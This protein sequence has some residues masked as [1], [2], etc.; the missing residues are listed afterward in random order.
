MRLGGRQALDSSHAFHTYLI[1]GGTGSFGQAMTA[2]LLAQT[3][4]TIRIYSRSELLHAQMRQR[5]G[6]ARVRYCLGDVRDLARLQTALVDVDVCFHAA[7]LKHVDLGQYNPSEVIATNILGTENVASAC[8]TMGV[9]RAIFLSSD[10]GCHPVNVYGASKL[11]GQELWCRCNAYSPHR[12]QYAAVRYGNVAT[13]RGSVLPR[14]RQQLLETQPLTLTDPRMSRF[15]IT[16][17]EAVQVAW[18]A[19]HY[20][21]RG[22]SLVPH[23]P[24]YRVPALAEAVIRE[25]APAGMAAVSIEHVGMRPGEKLAETLASDDELAT[26]LTYTTDGATPL[27]YALPPVA[28]SWAMPAVPEWPA[29]LG[30]T[31][32][33]RPVEAPYRSDVWSYQLTVPELQAR[34]REARA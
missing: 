26:A 29:P 1:T 10:K 19:A 22:A 33:Q 7:A 3:D 14:W 4:A 31:W 9:Q 34:L 24:A 28:P 16:L 13:S 27:Y 32:L 12:T 20:A 18:F 15:W 21:P 6:E 17:P 8:R 2:F 23:L 11:L 5:F 30:G 25:Y